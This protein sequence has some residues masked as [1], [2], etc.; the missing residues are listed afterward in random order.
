MLYEVITRVTG[1][2]DPTAP[3][4]ETV[5]GKLPQIKLT[6]EAAAGFSAYGNQI[7]LTT[8]QVVEYYDP[9]F[10]SYNFV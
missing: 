6:R 2:A 7:G 8:G 3:M 4:A 9:G 1:A 5:P 10:L